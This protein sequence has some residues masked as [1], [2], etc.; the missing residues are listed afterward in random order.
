MHE[1]VKII[2]RTHAPHLP[3]QSFAIE[4][5]LG[6]SVGES[7]RALAE[8]ITRA[9]LDAAQIAEITQDLNALREA[10][11]QASPQRVRERIM[12]PEKTDEDVYRYIAFNP[13]R[14]SMNPLAAPLKI[15]ADGDVVRGEVRFGAAYEGPPGHV[16]GGHVAA[17]FDDFLACVQA[18]SGTRGFTGTLEIRFRAPTPLYT[19]LSLE[20]NYD[21]VEGR[22]ILTHGAIFAS[23]ILTAEAKG[24]FIAPTPEHIE[25]LRR[26]MRENAKP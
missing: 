13:I 8:Q 7:L 14:G 22:K 4:D 18:L 3:W 11:E 21:G 15:W 19:K 5:P 20:G 24:T 2:R 10:F 17:I 1:R 26:A 6:D 16:H 23:G 12:G 25:N 9:E